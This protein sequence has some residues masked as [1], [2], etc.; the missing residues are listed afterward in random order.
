MSAAGKNLEAIVKAVE[1]HNLRCTFPPTAVAMNPF[2][3]ERLGW[4]TIVGLPIVGDSALSTGRFRVL[5]DKDSEPEEGTAEE[6]VVTN[7][8]GRPL[9]AA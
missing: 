9:V 5:C 8:I 7:V 6:Q 2:E 3:V 1:D 4:D